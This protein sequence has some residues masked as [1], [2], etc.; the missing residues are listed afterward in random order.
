MNY[1]LV[2]FKNKKKQRIIK[3]F[4]TLDKA[5][6]KYE[7]LLK[8]S[9]EVIFEKKTEN[10]KECVYELGL[11]EFGKKN[12][13]QVFI[14]DYLGRNIKVEID[15]EN[16]NIL[17]IQECKLEELF[18]DYKTKKKINTKYFIKT[19]L[20]GS[21]LK[22]VSKLNNKIIVQNDDIINIFTFKSESDGLRF[23]ERLHQ[24]LSKQGKKD[25]I[26]VNDYS[27]IH[28]KYLYKLLID[29]GFP[30]E[31]L[32]RYSTAHLSKR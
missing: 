7:S 22:Q 15:D 13:N 6:K 28:R 20:K 19:Y 16:Y 23:T 8:E 29:V 24:E 4:L 5:K 25:C 30:I 32:Q 3:K 14:R 26:I 2:L 12:N 31:Y 18:L 1:Q 9:S 10:G 21:G 17:K 11:L 27:T